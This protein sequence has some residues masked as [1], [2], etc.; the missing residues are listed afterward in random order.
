MH[1]YHV[2]SHSADN[3]FYIVFKILEASLHV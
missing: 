3:V 1:I 2:N